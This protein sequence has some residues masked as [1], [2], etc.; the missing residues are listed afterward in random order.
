ML[1]RNSK[2]KKKKMFQYLIPSILM[3]FAM[4]FGSL[5]DCI[6]VGNLIGNDALTASSLVLPILF[7]IQLIRCHYILLFIY[8][9]NQIHLRI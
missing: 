6:L 1:E 5:V 9:F 8:L 7:V 2:K 4:Q 3:I